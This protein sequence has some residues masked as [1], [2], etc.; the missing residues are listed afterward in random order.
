MHD[1]CLCDFGTCRCDQRAPPTLF[2]SS[3][4]VHFGRR[5]RTPYHYCSKLTPCVSPSQCSTVPPELTVYC[6]SRGNP[7]CKAVAGK[8]AARIRWV[9]E[10]NSSPEE[11]DHGDGTVTVLSTF[12]G[13]GT[14]LNSTTCF[15]SHP[16]M[17][18]NQSIACLSVLSQALSTGNSVL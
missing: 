11:E 13:N 8:P 2:S 16:A 5:I 1:L 3:H 17:I 7:V 4:C 15:V 9:P 10:S 18:H 12:T 14:N 6:D